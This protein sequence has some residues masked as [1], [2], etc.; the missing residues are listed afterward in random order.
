V[1]D[2]L[3]AWGMVTPDRH[4]TEYGEHIFGLIEGG[5]DV[6]RFDALDP[7]LPND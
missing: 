2:Q 7:P 5:D 3:R 4:L 1:F 6:P